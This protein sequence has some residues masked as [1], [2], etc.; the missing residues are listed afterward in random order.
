MRESVSLL[1]SPKNDITYTIKTVDKL[2]DADS[3]YL[4]TLKAGRIYRGLP[5]VYACGTPDAFLEYSSETDENGINIIDN[6]GWEAI[7][8][9]NSYAR[10]GNDCSGALT[11][12][13]QMAGSSVQAKTTKYM[14][15]KYGFIKV[16]DY[17]SQYDDY[18]GGTVPIATANGEQRMFEAYAKLQKSDAVVHW[19]GSGHTL[20]AVDINVVRN[21]D[22]TIN[23]DSSNIV[24]LEQTRRFF[25][26]ESAYTDAELGTVYRIGGVDVKHSFT[27]LYETGYLPITCREFTNADY[28]DKPKFS[29]S[30]S[31]YNRDT[32]F[33]GIISSNW[34]INKMKIEISSGGSVL[35][36]AMVSV[37]RSNVFSFDM[38]QFITDYDAAIR[39]TG[40]DL[41]KLSAG[42]YNCKVLC[43]LTT[44][45]VFTLRNFDFQI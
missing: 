32:L 9:G 39:G 10:I 5:Y 23:G 3:E 14:T 13:W 41:S 27:K 2:A 19:N 21:E 31:E 30:I 18:T 12:A 26:S 45:E 25:T 37:A 38:Q 43:Y 15:E 22:G 24:V 4:W 20:M 7:S 44:G 17:D 29:D 28:I 35:Q 6:L 16:G 36:D 42:T 33:T 1:W 34:S 8:R 11:R 40:I